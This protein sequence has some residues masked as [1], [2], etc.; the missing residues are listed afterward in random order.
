MHILQTHTYIIIDLINKIVKVSLQIN[1]K[2]TKEMLT[3]I[4]KRE[5]LYMNMKKWKSCTIL[6]VGK[7]GKLNA[8]SVKR[9]TQHMNCWVTGILSSIKPV[10]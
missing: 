3:A 4:N 6:L 9:K 2:V 8:K 5:K 7:S 10:A 1:I